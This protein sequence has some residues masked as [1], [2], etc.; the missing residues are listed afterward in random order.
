MF[1]HMLIL[2]IQAIAN[3]Y[4]Y[5]ILYH[6]GFHFFFEKKL[7][8]KYTLYHKYLMLDKKPMQTFN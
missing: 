2:D 5:S 7:R 8:R 3:T 4:L 1:E 6:F